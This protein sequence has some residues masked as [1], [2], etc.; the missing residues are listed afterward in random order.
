ML[1]AFLVSI[2]KTPSLIPLFQLTNLHTPASLSWHSPKLGL[3]A[4][5]GPRASPPIDVQQGHHLLH[6]KLYSWVPPYVIFA[7]WFSPWELWGTGWFI[8]VF[9]LWGY[10][11]LQLLESFPSSSIVDHVLSLL[12]ASTSVFVRH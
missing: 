11:P 1:S 9:L 4:F 2:L 10:K 5:T 3:R 8:L 12:R 7:W 6:L